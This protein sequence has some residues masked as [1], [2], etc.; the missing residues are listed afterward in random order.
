MTAAIPFAAPGEELRGK[1]S[2]FALR[3]VRNVPHA[4]LVRDV[5]QAQQRLARAGVTARDRV[6]LIGENC[7]Q[8][9]VFDLALQ[10]LD[11]HPVC[12]PVDE[13]ATVAWDTLADTYGLSLLLVT[14]RF[15]GRARPP[16]VL[17]VDEEETEPA[18]V[19]KT[20]DGLLARIARTTDLCTIVFSSGTSGK[21]KALLLSRSGVDS[22]VDAL[23][24]EWAISPSDGVLVALPLSIFQQRILTYAALRADAD[25]HFTDPA[26][27][28][29]SF[30]A[31]RPTFVLAPPALFETIENRLGEDMRASRWRWLASRALGLVPFRTTRERWRQ[32]LFPAMQESFGG[33][34]RALLTGS[35]PSKV[36]TLEMFEAAGLPLYQAYGLAEAGFVAWNRPGVNKPMT[37]GRPVAGASISIADDG[38]IIVAMRHRQAIGYFEVEPAEEAAVFLPDGRVAT[39]DLG[40]IDRDGYLSILGRK[41]NL[42][43][44]QSGEKISVETIEAR[45]AAVPGVKQAV[46][47]GGSDVAWLAAIVGIDPACEPADEARARRAVDAA[48]DDHNQSAKANARI[49]KVLMIRISFSPENGLATRNMKPDRNAIRR[50]FESE[51]M[52]DQ[53]R[54]I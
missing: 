5:R 11:C 47:I 4:A 43:L 44:R 36:S 33:R 29:H 48:I 8:W 53:R 7:Y 21:L 25:V 14:K 20:D 51:L 9:I 35:A 49:D 22:V 10:S 2:I 34:I 54:A 6:G 16:W 13:F 46:V 38:E 24:H 50:R 31:L 32:Q 1:F 45:L 15:S 37:V 40:A 18:A 42:I 28:F 41:K 26:N 27:L 23:V 19:R 12:F 52:S 17:A 30:K 39:G 3:V